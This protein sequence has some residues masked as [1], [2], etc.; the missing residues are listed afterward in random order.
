MRPNPTNQ[1][2]VAAA[3]GIAC[4]RGFTSWGIAHAAAVLCSYGRSWN[5]LAER[6]VNGIADRDGNWDERANERAE[7]R[8]KRLARLAAIE[9][10]SRGAARRL[11]VRPND[12]YLALE[13][14]DPRHPGGWAHITNLF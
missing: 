10:E 7:A 13:K 11:R 9:I 1:A 5:R 4:P 8:L 3:L 12:L 6:L 2:H 14:R